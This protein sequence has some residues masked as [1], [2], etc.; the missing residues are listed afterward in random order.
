MRDIKINRHP[1][2]LSR[3]F[4]VSCSGA[5]AACRRGLAKAIVR[6]AAVSGLA[7]FARG[8]LFAAC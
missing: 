2:F 6:I 7:L 1:I 8:L 5:V 4:S 3:Y